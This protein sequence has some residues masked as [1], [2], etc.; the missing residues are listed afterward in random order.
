MALFGRA[1]DRFGDSM[2]RKYHIRP[3]RGLLEPVDK[4]GPH[5]LKPVDHETVVNDLM[6][7]IHRR[8]IFRERKLDD[9]DGPLDTGTK[10]PGRSQEQGQQ[11]LLRSSAVAAFH[12]LSAWLHSAAVAAL[13]EKS[14]S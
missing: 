8:A 10:T 13:N 3:L 5:A 1:Y 11:W 6:P 14:H 9:A 4:D 7:D 12:A 2:G